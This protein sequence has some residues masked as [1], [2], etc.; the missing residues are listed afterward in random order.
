MTKRERVLKDALF[1]MEKEVCFVS[2]RCASRTPKLEHSLVAGESGDDLEALEREL[3]A[4]RQVIARQRVGLIRLRKQ[5]MPGYPDEQW[6]SEQTLNALGGIYAG[7]KP[8]LPQLKL[9][10]CNA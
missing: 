4:L 2:G 5:K 1:S 8:I 3:D 10:H 9:L 7:L 6:V